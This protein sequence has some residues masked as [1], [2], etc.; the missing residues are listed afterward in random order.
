[1]AEEFFKKCR[2]FALFSRPWSRA[3]RKEFYI[4]PTGTNLLHHLLSQE[5]S[6]VMEN[7]VLV[8]SGRITRRSS[9]RLA[10]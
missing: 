8:L 5:S 10:S 3:L 6:L 7:V 1:M 9:Q 2:L 4:V